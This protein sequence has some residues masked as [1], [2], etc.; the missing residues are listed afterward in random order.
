MPESM[1]MNQILETL[2]GYREKV[3]V[4]KPLC[5]WEM[6]YVSS[7]EFSSVFKREKRHDFVG[8][9]GGEPK[10]LDDSVASFHTMTL[11]EIDARIAENADDFTNSFLFTYQKLRTELFAFRT[12]IL[13]VSE[14]YTMDKKMEYQPD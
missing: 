7:D 11:E 12:E 9:F 8:V 6:D 1:S 5:F 10:N 4:V 2:H 3:I 13:L 14:K